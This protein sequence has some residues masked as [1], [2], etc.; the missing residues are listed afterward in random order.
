MNVIKIE[1]HSNYNSGNLNNDFSILKLKTSIDYCSY[2]HIRPVCLPSD[3]GLMYVG[4]T[5][6]VTGWGTT[7][8]GGTVSNKLREVDVKVLSN[9]QCK[10]DYSYSSSSITQNMLCAAVAG[11]GKDSC[12]GDSGGPLVT[13][14][15]G[16]NYQ[17]IGVVSWGVGCAQADAPGV[18]ARWELRSVLVTL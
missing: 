9:S 18:Y 4:D 10:N 3:T 17:Q 12:Q 2:P 8:S 6:T 5:A 16:E 15:S 11:G 7:S 13:A 14:R 1:I